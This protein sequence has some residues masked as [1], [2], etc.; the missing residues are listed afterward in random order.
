M[1]NVRPEFDIFEGN[2]EDLPIRFQMIKCHMIFDVKL[3]ENF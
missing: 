2:K 3:G 1:K